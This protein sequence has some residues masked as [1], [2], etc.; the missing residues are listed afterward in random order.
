VSLRGAGQLLVGLALCCMVA[1]AWAQQTRPQGMRPYFQLNPTNAQDL[2]AQTRQFPEVNRAAVLFA[3]V[4]VLQD[5]GFRVTGGE[6]RCGLLVGE[7]IADVPGAGLTHAVGEAVLVTA[8]TILSVAVGENLIMD[9]PE[10]VA[11]RIHVSLLVSVEDGG[12]ATTVRISLDR[13]MIYDHG[14]IIPDHTELPLVYQEF[15]ERLS[16]AVFLEG[17]RL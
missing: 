13:D 17:E 14:H 15:F 7:K 3:S 1:I 16:R 6:R 4:G 9:L 8:T 5:M 11:Q 10:Q 2:G 12:Q